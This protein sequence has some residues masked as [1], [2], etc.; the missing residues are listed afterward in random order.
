MNAVAVPKR[1]R[2]RI[3]RAFE[4]SELSAVDKP[5][6][7]GARVAIMKRDDGGEEAF[8]KALVVMT[9][10]VAGHV[11]VIELAD[12]GGMTWA[13]SSPG[14]ESHSHPWIIRGDGEIV[15]G[16]AEGHT[17]DV[18]Q[19]EARA[20]LERLLKAR[21]GAIAAEVLGVPETLPASL[22]NIPLAAELPDVDATAEQRRA[23]DERNARRRD[24]A[25]REA[26][27]AG[28]DVPLSTLADL[29]RKLEAIARDRAR[30]NES[31]QQAFAR[32]VASGDDET[33]TT[34]LR[35]REIVARHG[36]GATP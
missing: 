8:A 21:D 30:D 22:R 11:H 36:P 25:E 16:E 23:I 15:V 10:P 19:A 12:G 4:I 20:V 27:L 1:R 31:M 18:D 5:A 33:F 14:R 29:D 28:A 13:S 17:H 6:Q 32:L 24:R 26:A 9:E 35:L 7:E 2:R 34:T 3:M